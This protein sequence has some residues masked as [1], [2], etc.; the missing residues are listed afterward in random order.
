MTEG[1]PDVGAACRLSCSAS[2]IEARS[3]TEGE[4]GVSGGSLSPS[5]SS[6]SE[7]ESDTAA[8]WHCAG[9]YVEEP[10]IFYISPRLKT[11]VLSFR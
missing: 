5:N 7:D 10:S 1:S 8:L 6:E 4:R 2:E 9:L 3:N 11:F